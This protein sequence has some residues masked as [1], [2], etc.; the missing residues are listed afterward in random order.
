M[1][2]R[3][4]HV[5]LCLLAA[6][7]AAAGAGCAQQ[8]Q[9]QETGSAQ[10]VGMVQQALGASEVRRVELTVSAPDMASR[11]EVLTKTGSLW[12]GVLHQLPV[13]TQRTFRAQAYG[14]SNAL[15]YAGEATDI[16]ISAGQ[17]TAVTLTLQQVA[18]PPPFA[19]AAPVITS[20]VATPGAV[21]S[22]GTVQLQATAQDA[23]PGDSLTF[24]WTAEAGSF[25]EASSSGTTWTAPQAAGPVTLTLKV[26]D[27][28]G[29]LAT[30][31]VTLM[32]RAASGSAAVNVA[33]NSWPQVLD[34]S[35]SS[36]QVDVGESTTLLASASDNDNDALGYQWTSSCEGT[37]ESASS[38]NAR[39]TPTA[40][41]PAEALCASCA[42]TVTVTD[43]RGGQ[44][45]GTLSLCVGPKLA[46]QLPPEVVETYQSVLAIPAS[47]EPVTFRLKALDPQ[48]SPLSFSWRASTGTLAP[49]THGATTSEVLWTAPACIPAGSAPTLTAT[50]TNALGLSA[51][52]SFSVSGGTVCPVD[53]FLA[54][55]IDASQ[56]YSVALKADGTVW[57]WG[58]NESDRMGAGAPMLSP[59]SVPIQVQGFTQATAIA[60]SDTHTLALRSDGTV[61]GV[62][63]NTSGQLGDATKVSSR[64]PVQAL[65]LPQVTAIASG[66]RHS[67]ALTK[68]GTVWAWGSNA[69]GQLGVDAPLGSLV[70]RPL[71]VEGLTEVT[72]IAADNARTVALR[73]DGTVWR[74]GSDYSTRYTV[75][76]QVPGLTQVTAIAAGS[77]HCVALRA[78]GTVWVWGENSSGQ[79]GDNRTRSGSAVPVQVPG[80]TQVTAIDAEGG[81]I[82]VQRE[83]GTLWEWGSFASPVPRQREGVTQVAAFATGSSHGLAMKQDGTVWS[84]GSN[85]RGQLGDGTTTDRPTPVQVVSP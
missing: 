79:L 75:P 85:F 38:P 59:A 24:A 69:E 57:A 67:V 78:D 45:T 76:T 62:G 46:A 51:S 50:V 52:T 84:W 74:W 71:P 72:A 81:S 83:D 56:R 28:Q 30:T 6:V 40:Q 7:W 4:S 10:V 31:S 73:A 66:W 23:N 77:Y 39:F 53:P 14:A 32:V 1:K 82:L 61:W 48:G 15:L 42:L 44:T 11:T 27:S 12:G 37:W 34:V 9:Q 47:G 5:L 20:L 29:A 63:T 80:L 13:G 8:Q 26:T 60:A 58:F 2:R 17:T 65:G 33:F 41:P 3:T 36:T 25:S 68:D 55:D 19:N 16:T 70:P 22:G 64:M 49:P 18:A 43:G 54:T 35:A 21:L